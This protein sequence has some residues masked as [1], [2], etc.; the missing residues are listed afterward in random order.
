VCSASAR[1]SAAWGPL[2]LRPRSLRP[3][4]AAA[5]AFSARAVA[6]DRALA[7]CV[8][9]SARAASRRARRPL[10]VDSSAGSSATPKSAHGWP[11]AGGARYSPGQGGGRRAVPAAIRRAG[12]DVATRG[13]RA[14]RHERPHW[15]PFHPASGRAAGPSWR[16]GDRRRWRQRTRRPPRTRKLLQPPS[17]CLPL[18]PSAREECHA[19]SGVLAGCTCGARSPEE[20]G[21]MKVQQFGSGLLLAATVWLGGCGTSQTAVSP[22]AAASRP[23]ALGG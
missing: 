9:I 15:W 8:S 17:K 5:Q 12:P 10:W 6:S 4:A 7:S 18:K 16:S 14:G 11:C 2:G 3:S 19:Q 21:K 22:A 13:A 20:V 23:P 1:A